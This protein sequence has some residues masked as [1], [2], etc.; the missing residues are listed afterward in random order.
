MPVF[1]KVA[2]LVRSYKRHILQMG[3][4][5]ENPTKFEEASKIDYEE[6]VTQLPKLPEY[7]DEEASKNSG[8]SRSKGRTLSIGPKSSS[9]ASSFQE[10]SSRAS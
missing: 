1:D 6:L 7:K 4:C 3:S 2:K 9:A 8:K 5:K 10:S